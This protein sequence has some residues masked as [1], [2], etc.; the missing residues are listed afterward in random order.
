[1]DPALDAEWIARMSTAEI[2]QLRRNSGGRSV[3]FKLTFADGRR[4][5]WKPEQNQSGGSATNYVSEIAA[6]HIDR[7]LGLRRVAPVSGRA[8]GL[9]RLRA[10]MRGDTEILGR[11]QREVI[12]REGQVRGATIAWLDGTLGSAIPPQAWT[13]QTRGRPVAPQMLE[14][15]REWTDL[16]VFDFLIDNTDRWS[17]GNIRTLGVGGPLIFLDNGAGFNQ[18]RAEHD[19]VGMDILQYVCRFKRTTIAQLRAMGPDAPEGQRLGARLRAAMARDVLGAETLG[20][21]HYRALDF[22]VGRLLQHVQ[23]C[24]QRFGADRVTDI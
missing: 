17:G 9:S 10:A 19:R 3:M 21:V 13:G 1:M 14:R 23:R 4:A 6:H 15:V 18:W 12:A 16:V 24:E 20:D 2:T 22:R 11:I 7:I 5:V 8:I